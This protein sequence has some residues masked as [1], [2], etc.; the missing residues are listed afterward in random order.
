MSR[1]REGT[2]EDLGVGEPDVP[3]PPPH[4]RPLTRD[5]QFERDHPDAPG[6][7]EGENR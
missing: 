3:W 7:P 2:L 5:E 6:Q 1:P 4:Q